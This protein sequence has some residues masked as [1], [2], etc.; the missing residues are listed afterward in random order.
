MNQ[1]L[2]CFGNS[3]FCSDNVINDKAGVV[4]P[5]DLEMFGS[6]AAALFDN[7][8]LTFFVFLL[9]AP[10]VRTAGFIIRART[11]FAVERVFVVLLAD[12]TLH[13][14]RLK[15]RTLTKLGRQPP[16]EETLVVLGPLV[17]PSE[18]VNV[19]V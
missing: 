18:P 7:P 5:L 13:A 11:A 9:P 14:D 3:I 17:E 15:T 12:Y 19:C 2:P 16:P 10:P 8:R 1:L 4:Q 6:G